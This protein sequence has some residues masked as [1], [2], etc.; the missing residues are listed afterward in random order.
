MVLLRENILWGLMVGAG[1]GEGEV[2]DRDC[3]ES[4]QDC[5]AILQPSSSEKEKE[6]E[7]A[8]YRN[9]LRF[10]TIFSVCSIAFGSTRS[11]HLFSEL[12]DCAC[13]E[14]HHW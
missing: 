6:K 14:P 5:L 12:H 3:V 10:T 9:G 7:P 1:F 13:G 2:T 4:G 11:R 8:P